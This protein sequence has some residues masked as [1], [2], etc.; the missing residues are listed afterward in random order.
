MV[1]RH[2][3]IP[4]SRSS[5]RRARAK[6]ATQVG[7][8][9][10]I[11][12]LAVII[13]FGMAGTGLEASP[14]SEAAALAAARAAVRMTFEADV[15]PSLDDAVLAPAQPLPFVTDGADLL[16]RPAGPTRIVIVSVGIDALVNTVGYTFEDGAL[17]YDVPRREAG[18]YVDS[19]VP[20]DRGNVVIGGHVANRGG[21]AVFASLPDV[22]AGDIVQVYRGDQVF[23]YSITEIK[24][25]AAEA[26]S[27]MS[28]TQD[29][30][31]TLITC[32]PE[33]NYP[34]RLVVVGKLV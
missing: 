32:F 20:G 16:M 3:R 24:V 34:H 7:A 4:V 21:Q 12:V 18:H 6:T 26:T 8:G 1:Q 19:A 23:R 17:Q 9:F 11:A 13:G 10:V 31:L 5:A 25:V 14:V 15:R 22:K 27:V 28:Q 30:R 33:R 2:A 29:A